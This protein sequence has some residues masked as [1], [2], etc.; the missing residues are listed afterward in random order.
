MH[1]IVNRH[2]SISKGVF[3]SNIPITFPYSNDF[4]R[5]KYEP[6]RKVSVVTMETVIRAYN[7]VFYERAG[8]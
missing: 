4:P 2:I 8:I 5:N 3:T 7:I 6:P 1:C